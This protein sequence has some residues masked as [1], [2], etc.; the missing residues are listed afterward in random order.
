SW[1]SLPWPALNR[2]FSLLRT[3]EECKDL[4][5]IAMVSTYF[6]AEVKKFMGTPSNRPGVDY[7]RF[8]KSENGLEIGMTFFPTNIPFYDLSR[9][10][11]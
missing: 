10:D 1:E 4:A 3:D 8:S 2:V 7:A 9:L 6:R 5:N 11:W